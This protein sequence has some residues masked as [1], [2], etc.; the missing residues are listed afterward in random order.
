MLE[1]AVAAY[2]REFKPSHQLDHPYVIAGVNV[3]A[4]DTREAAGASLE[5]VRR[6]LAVS[7]FGRGQLYD[8]DLADA[9][10][11]QVAG[12]HVDTML[13]HTALGTPAEVREHLDEFVKL[14]HADELIVAH[15]A[16][17]T[18]ARLRSVTLLAEAMGQ[19]GS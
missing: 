9:L 18:E 16:S 4:A 3:V 1:P 13:T 14:T 11:S 12:A 10:L 7:L 2:R 19:T 15:Q 5:Q 6:N 8:D 17:D